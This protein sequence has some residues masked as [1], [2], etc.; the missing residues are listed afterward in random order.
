MTTVV[1]LQGPQSTNQGKVIDRISVRKVLN[2]GQE[3]M[4]QKV[5]WLLIPVQTILFSDEISV[6]M[7]CHS[8]LALEFVYE[9]CERCVMHL[10]SCLCLWQMYPKCK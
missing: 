5:M 1:D 7:Y 8:H 2:A 3:D 10:L 9:T 6:R 4:S